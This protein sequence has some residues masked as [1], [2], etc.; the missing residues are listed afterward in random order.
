MLKLEKTSKL[1]TVTIRMRERERFFE[2]RLLKALTIALLLHC[3]ALLMFQVTPFSFTST[4]LFP[5]IHVQSNSTI[6]G[7]VAFV[8]DRI[9]KENAFPPPLSFVPSL[10]SLSFP[11]ESI[12]TPSYTFDLQ[13]LDPLEKHIWPKWEVPLSMKL[14]EPRIQLAISGPLA[15]LSLVT[16]DPLLEEMQPI[17]SHDF[18]AYVTYKVMLD[19]YTG[20]IFWH[21]R[22][23]SST[24]HGMN[25]LT[26][27]ILLNLRFFSEKQE[28]P[29][30]GVL[31]FLLLPSIK[32]DRPNLLAGEL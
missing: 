7:I 14:E 5:P 16:G 4:F 30:S 19:P 20:E 12:L 27:K 15:K 3:G 29:V 6:K 23:E 26:E 9:E 17:S 31:H 10:E 13:L 18:A 25:R 32:A 2:P 8:S 28:E 24:D 11:P 1:S 22:I 21:E